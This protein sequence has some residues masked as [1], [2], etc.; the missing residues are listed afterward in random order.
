VAREMHTINEIG[1]GRGQ[2]D[3]RV[4]IA[5]AIVALIVL[6][7]IWL[8]R[9][10]PEPEPIPEPARPG[11]TV[12]PAESPEERGDSAREFINELSSRESG[13]DYAQ[14]YERARA[15]QSDGRLADAQLLL[16]FAARHGHGQS[17]FDLATSYDPNHHSP[18]SSL[19]NEPDPFQAYR[20]YREAQDAGHE[21]ASE[22]LGDLR[23]WAEQAAGTG[24]AEAER[25]LLQWE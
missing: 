4:V 22:R 14:A 18:A 19:M 1:R 9:R 5:L 13:V 6:A 10:E 12:S 23:A 16:F 25:L 20:W 2:V 21:S 15:F 3:L 8:V 7:A 24:N 11:E 17:A